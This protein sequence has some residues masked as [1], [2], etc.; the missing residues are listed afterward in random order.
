M[1]L[2]PE[3]LSLTNTYPVTAPKISTL[4]E[5]G[6]G[7]VNEDAIVCGNNSTYGVFDGAT[8][9][10]PTKYEDDLTG[11][12]IASQICAKVFGDI[13][14]DLRECARQAN[15]K[16]NQHAKAS[17]VN[18]NRKEELWSVSAAVVRL[19]ANSFNWCQIGD[20]HILLI[21]NDN[22]YTLLTRDPGHDV[23]TLQAWQQRTEESDGQ[24]MEVMAEEILNVRRRMNIAYGVLNGEQ[25]AL[26][27]LQTGKESLENVKDILIFSD[28]LI[29]PRRNPADPIDLDEIV[30]L[31]THGELQSLRDF[32]RNKE[33]SDLGCRRLR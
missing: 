10:V 29:P 17:G 31:Y 6:S 22:S 5:K 21:Y 23:A 1:Y 15:L 16:I 26:K 2:S 8:S 11:G 32:V 18:F 12:N 7:G 30:S 27:F 14:G 13:P 19:H 20:C 4:L 9:L 33:L 28:G 24:I 25:R 3:Q